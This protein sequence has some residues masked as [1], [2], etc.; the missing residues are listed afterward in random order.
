MNVDFPYRFDGHGRTASTTDEDHI[1]DMI[2]QLLFTSPGERV[3]RPDFGSGLLQLVFAPNSPELAATLQ[4]T[5]RA[6]LQQWLG[7]VI[8]VED[9]RV[10]SEDAT[11]RVT[12]AYAS[13]RTQRREVATFSRNGVR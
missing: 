2:E 6:A 1:R 3:N 7:D 10:E 5:L 11:L 9:L 4:F 13:R 8:Q 12:V